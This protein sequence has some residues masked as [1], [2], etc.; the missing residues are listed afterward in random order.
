MSRWW[1][2]RRAVGLYL[3][4]AGE[5]SKGGARVWMEQLSV[6]LEHVVRR[7]FSP[8]LFAP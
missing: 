3:K 5:R 1:E 4:M 7:R 6:R 2:R 8:R